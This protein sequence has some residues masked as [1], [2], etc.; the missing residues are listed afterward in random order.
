AQRLRSFLTV[1]GITMGV[2]TLMAVI[3]MVQGANTYVEQKIANLGTNVFQVGKMP[4]AS[5]NFDEIIKARR[6]RDIKVEDLAAVREACTECE[7]VGAEANTVT[8]VRYKDQEL[9]DQTLIGQTSNMSY[10]GTRT[11][12]SGR[13]F[14][15]L[16]E[17]HNA[18]VCLVGDAVRSKMFAGVN[19]LGRTVR[20]GANE[21]TVI[22][23]FERIG[24]VLGQEQ[25]NFVVIPL[26]LF[27]KIVGLRTSIVI[28]CK[29]EGGDVVFAQAQDQARLVMRTRRHITGDKREDFYIGTAESYITLW[30]QISSSFFTVFLMLSS[31]AAVVG[32]IVIMNIMLVSVTE[33][34][35][36]IGIRRAC[37]ARQADI[38]RQFL[39]ESVLLCVA[40]GVVGVL[41]G[42]M[43]A[44]VVRMLA[45]FPATVKL[46]AAALGVVMSSGIG[47]FFGIYP[48]VKAA[49]LD[50][51]V[52]LRA[53]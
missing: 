10:I 24:S 3:T 13:Y 39:T 49:R 50:P 43:A 8:S 16:E 47:L 31:I 17:R 5:T 51:V 29:A 18:P 33:R 32:G 45:D 4:F 22:G 23:V 19:P 6:N 53:D 34:T 37:G 36:E 9:Q 40:G 46:W 1:L 35:K 11:V 12:G 48:A 21:F 42:F 2:A 27:L 38:L 25:D 44:F 15:E 14:S 26:P 52:A 30:K 7:A 20:M 41:L 28:D